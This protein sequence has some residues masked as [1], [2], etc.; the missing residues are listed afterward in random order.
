CAFYH[1]ILEGTE[2]TW[3]V[4]S[5]CLTSLVW[6]SGSRHAGC[7]PFEFINVGPGI[8]SF[9][10]VV[11]RTR[12]GQTIVS[13]VEIHELNFVQRSGIEVLPGITGAGSAYDHIP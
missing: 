3:I 4:H 1:G 2:D 9:L 10:C 13:A 6:S 12:G 7:G 8:P 11:V 5:H